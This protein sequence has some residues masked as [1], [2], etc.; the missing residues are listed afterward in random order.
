MDNLDLSVLRTAAGWR[1]EARGV[2]LGT[3]TRTW[4]S[5]PRPVGLTGGRAGRRADRRLG[6]GRLHRGRP[7]RPAAR[8]Q[9]D[10]WTRPTPLRYG[11]GA[12]EA[13][14]FGLPCGGTLELMLEPLAAAVGRWTPCWPGWT[15]GERVRRMLDLATGTVTLA[16][17]QPGGDTLDADRHPARQPPR[18]AVA[19]AHHRRRPDDRLYLAQMAQA[20]D[21]GVTVCDPARRVHRGLRRLPGTTLT[22]DMPDDV[23][24]AFQGRRRPRPSWP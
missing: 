19:A 21:Y 5:A 10:A 1:A 17:A 18:P 7:G 14:R 12:E 23:V 11:V 22:R 16:D 20:L 9:P 6:V 13:R 4:G 2:V 8:R 3:I 15:R 24:T